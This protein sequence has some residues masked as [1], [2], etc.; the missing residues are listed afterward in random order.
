MLLQA[1]LSIGFS[2]QKYWRR[3]PFP[4]QGDLSHPEI[5]PVCPAVAGGFFT[6]KPP[7]KPSETST[8]PLIVTSYIPLHNSRDFPDDSG[9]KESACNARDTGLI[10]ESGRYHWEGNGNPLQYSCLG[11]SMDRG[12]WWPMA[13]GVT[14]SQTQLKWLT[15]TIVLVVLLFLSC[16]SPQLFTAPSWRD[17]APSI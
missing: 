16:S 3:L 4:S 8:S 13:H 9:G 14:K 11:N 12:T 17:D 2:R 5:K 15:T 10:P 6:T 1:P 7:G